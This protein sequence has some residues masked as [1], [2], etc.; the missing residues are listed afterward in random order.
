MYKF[1]EKQL[2]K[3]LDDH[4]GLVVEYIKKHDYTSTSRRADWQALNDTICGLEAERELV[5]TGAMEHTT[6]QIYCAKQLEPHALDLLVKH[7]GILAD[8]A[9]MDRFRGQLKE[10]RLRADVLAINLLDE[11]R[12]LSSRTTHAGETAT[13]ECEHG[14]NPALCRQCAGNKYRRSFP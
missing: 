14:F 4:V 3:L 7:A 10:I 5:D 2:R 12:R 9:S 11:Q 8:I 6:M 13:P 1:T